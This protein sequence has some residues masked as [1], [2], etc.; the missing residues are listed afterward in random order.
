MLLTSLDSA[1]DSAAAIT[2]GTQNMSRAQLV[3]A[4]AHPLTSVNCP[5]SL[6]R[7]L[8]KSLQPVRYFMYRS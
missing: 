8:K 1:V 6:T 4:A 5:N 2:V 3:D 7:R